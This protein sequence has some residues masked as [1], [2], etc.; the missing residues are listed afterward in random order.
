MHHMITMLESIGVNANLRHAPQSVLV[1]ALDSLQAP[2][3]VREAILANDSRKCRDL[4]AGSRNELAKAES[5]QVNLS[6]WREYPFSVQSTQ[7]AWH[8]EPYGVQSQ[9]AVWREEI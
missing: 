5:V 4:I 8:E 1:R 7:D 6:P 9:Q 3:T 2:N